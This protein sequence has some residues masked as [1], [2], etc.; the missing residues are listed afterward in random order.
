MMRFKYVLLTAL[1]FLSVVMMVTAQET[2]EGGFQ[3][4]EMKLKGTCEYKGKTF[5]HRSQVWIDEIET[6]RE[7]WGKCKICWDG[8][9]IPGFE[10]RKD[11][12]KGKY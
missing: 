3:R 5:E 2:D 4:G 7:D 11:A 1:F 9:F 8:N 6:E 12:C 10:Q